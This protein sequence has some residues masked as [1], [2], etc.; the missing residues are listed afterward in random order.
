MALRSVRVAAIT[1]VAVLAALPSFA[2]AQMR[3]ASQR[4]LS[5]GAA[6]PVPTRTFDPARHADRLLFGRIDA[7]RGSILTVRA[8]SGRLVRVDASEAVRTDAYSAPLFIGKFVVI[9]GYDDSAK[10]LH[11]TSVMRMG[12]LTG[13]TQ[14]DR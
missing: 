6:D 13:R 4:A 5:R 8:R 12:Q 3:P 7:I 9:D 11:A 2:G 10:T 1:L 14:P